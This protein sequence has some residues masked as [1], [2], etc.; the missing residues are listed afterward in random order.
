V[1]RRAFAGVVAAGA[2]V[3]VVLVALGL[4]WLTGESGGSVPARRLVAHASLAPVHLFFGDPLAASVSVEVDAHVV[5]PAS[6]RVRPEFGPFTELAAPRVQ[7]VRSGRA[8][9]ITYRYELQCATE[10]CL[11]HVKPY[12]VSFPPAV[13][14]ARSQGRQLSV[15]AAWPR[16][17]VSSRLT[18]AD[19]SRAAPRFVGL[20]TVPAAQ[21][22]VS[23]SLVEVAATVV[24]AGL[25]LVAVV[26]AA[27]EV[28]AAARRRRRPDAPSPLGAAVG[29]VR[30]A[31]ARPAAAD[32]RKALGLLALVLDRDGRHAL[33]G[34]VDSA[35]WGADP[36][37][38]ARLLV[39]ANEAERTAER[40]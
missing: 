29:Y 40:G 3:T 26:L 19:A 33:A 6:V 32:R 27:V 11:P 7:T 8:A 31:A 22:A 18:A 25:G 10:A 28:A 38:P 35:A 14:A 24:G 1:S 21:Y 9:T 34:S 13:V 15:V 23:P 2:V 39:L 17:S 20:T 12:V 30:E 4:G 16:A 36:P 5:D 37:E